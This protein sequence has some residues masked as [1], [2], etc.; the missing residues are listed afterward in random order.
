[1]TAAGAR[2]TYWE[3]DVWAGLAAKAVPSAQ[4][5]SVWMS[6][7]FMDSCPDDSFFLRDDVQSRGFVGRKYFLSVN[8][9][10]CEKDQGVLSAKSSKRFRR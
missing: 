5:E 9:E 1:M 3:F 6:S 7:D 2:W 10:T 4:R 8:Y